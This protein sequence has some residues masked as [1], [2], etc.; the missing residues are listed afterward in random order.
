MCTLLVPH[1][2]FYHSPFH[3]HIHALM[4]VVV[5]NIVAI[6]ALGHSERACFTYI[7]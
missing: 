1:G 7:F 5:S 6:T 4:E 2:P 3:K